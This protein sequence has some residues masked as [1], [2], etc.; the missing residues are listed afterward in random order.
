MSW[1]ILCSPSCSNPLRHFGIRI[2]SMS[3]S[4]TELL[5]SVRF[6]V[7]KSTSGSNPS[8]APALVALGWQPSLA[9]C[10]AGTHE[11]QRHWFVLNKVKPPSSSVLTSEPCWLFTVAPLQWVTLETYQNIISNSFKSPCRAQPVLSFIWPFI[12]RSKLF[13]LHIG[14]F[15]NCLLLI[16]VVISFSLVRCH[17]LKWWF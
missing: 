15:S 14:L 6:G 5:L 7:S 4:T 17:P 1:N 9:I 11:L 8:F 10:W 13:K 16:F 12:F 2:K 3:L